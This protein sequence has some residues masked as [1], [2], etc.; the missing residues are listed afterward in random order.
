[1][2]ATPNIGL[3][4]IALGDTSWKSEEDT[5]KDTIDT[6]FDAA[7]GHAHDGTPGGGPPISH[8][9]IGGLGSVATLDVAASGDAASGQAVKGNDTRLTNSR[10]PSGT[11]GGVLAGTYPNP[12]F[13]A[14]MATQSELDAVAAAA[15]P[16]DATL[17]ALAGLN[18]TAG[19]VV[20]TAADT[21]TKRTLTAG[22]AKLAVTNGSGASGNPTVD[23]GSV[24]STDL[25]DGAS[26]YKAGGTDVAIAD[27]GTGA[28]S[29]SAARTALGLAIGSDVQAYDADLA[30][31]AALSS[32]GLV[33]RTGAGTAAARSVAAATGLAVTNG[34]GASGNPTIAPDINA[35]TADASPD[36][37]AD[38]VMTYDASAT[39]HKKVLLNNLPGGGGGGGGGSLTVREV[40][41]SPSDSAVTTI[42]FPNG[43]LGIA[44]HVATYTPA[45]ATVSDNV[46]H[47]PGDIPPTSPHASDDEFDDGSLAGAWTWLNQ[48]AA[49]AT[50]AKG[51]LH[52][53]C[54]NTGS[55]QLRALMKA[56][57][58][59]DFTVSA[60]LHLSPRLLDIQGAVL[61]L[62]NS[63][64]T[65]LLI[66]GPYYYS[67]S[68]GQLRIVF[69]L[70]GANN[71]VA[72]VQSNPSEAHRG[73]YRWRVASGTVYFDR[74][75]DGI[76]WLTAYSEAISAHLG[77]LDEIGLGFFVE[78]TNPIDAV[79]HWF[80]VEV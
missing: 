41:S 47:R 74:S 1:M 65:K 21:F 7:S 76:V 67:P 19:L 66:C 51:V 73:Y 5:N 14:D 35:L 56:A 43:T 33:A 42:V 57:P 48:G 77:A 44:S 20:E 25:S 72:S 17:T 18:S 39:A 28:S 79:A 80:R 9:N 63:A 61:V 54:A 26:L 10:A 22:S 36:G 50:E 23:L 29:A 70:N 2:S 30:A 59:G 8:L 27:G 62:S 6:L 52:F 55:N 40:D 31:V 16:L 24:A 13:A 38:Y 58:A 34:D 46:Y 53:A 15:Q 37:A 71:S 78:G 69:R 4:Y 64:H 32:A 12:S 75:D 45:A 68:G 60:R 11:A 49:T 3:T